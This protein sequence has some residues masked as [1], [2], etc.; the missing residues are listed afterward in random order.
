MGETLGTADSSPLGQPLGQL[1]SADTFNQFQQLLRQTALE[2]EATVV[3]EADRTT[4]DRTTT[5]RTTTDRTT[6]EIPSKAIGEQRFVLVVSPRFTALLQGHPLQAGTLYRTELTFTPAVI[7][8]FIQQLAQKFAQNDQ[9]FDRASMPFSVQQLQSQLGQT[10]PVLQSQFILQLAALLSTSAHCQLTETALRQQLAQEQLLNQVTTQI[11][12]SLE[13]PKILKTAVEHVRQFLQVDRLVIYQLDISTPLIHL[14]DSEQ[15]HSSDISSDITSAVNLVTQYGSVIYEARATKMIPSVMHVSDAYCF[16]QELREANWQTLEIADAIEDVEQRYQDV[17]CLL[18]FLRQAQV[19]A[20]LIAPIRLPDRLWG[21]LIA[22]ECHQPRQWQDNERRFL[23]Q[24]AENLAIAISQSQLYG[25]LQQQKQTLEMRVV[26]RTQALHDAMLTAQ[27]ANRAKSDFLAAVSHELR[28]PLACIIGMSAT[29]Q[30]WSKDVLNDR[31]QNFLQLIHE[32][33]EHLLALIN[34]ILD[35]SQAESGRMML[36]LQEFS[37][38]RLAHQ[39]LKAFEG[40]AAIQEV[41]LELDLH[42][43]P[44]RDQFVADPRRVRQ[45]LSNLLSNAIKFTPEGGRV[46]LRVFAQQELAIFQVKDTGIGIPERQLP[47]LFQKFQQLDSGYHREYQGT[48]LGL[49]LT[50]QLVELH[51]GW[52]EVESTAGVGSVF[53]V[54]LPTHPLERLGEQRPIL[55]S[56]ADLAQRRIVLI[57]PE[58]EVASVI[59][60]LLLA[61]GYQVVWV[62]E[63]SAAVHQLEVLSP[64]AVIVNVWLPD[65]DGS[66]FIQQLRR[67]PVTKNLKVLAL[68]PNKVIQARQTDWKRAGADDVL[69]QPIHPEALL[70]GIRRLLNQPLEQI[71]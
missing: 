57:E 55:T 54:K 22:H 11:R 40:Q 8:Q 41:E 29:L 50:K 15:F 71:D 14:V 18:E 69:Q 59:C 47:L 70:Q 3:T 2:L 16:M 66:Y 31:Q 37:L 21:L 39:T 61:A 28:T 5:D 34:D 43:D 38:S 44:A 1:L 45:I 24:I 26:E 52:I 23:Q 56:S 20:K 25:E 12:Q 68:L 33:G 49:A 51:Q 64:A 10:D 53:T 63:G 42:I 35:L 6:T 48:G 13:L 67:N 36:S 62:L 46:V 9:P 30:R 60:D 32:S 65:L 17:P 4:T 58:E 27:S 7:E 19:R